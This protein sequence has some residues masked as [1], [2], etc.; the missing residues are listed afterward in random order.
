MSGTS[1]VGLDRVVLLMDFM[2][3]ST[4]SFPDRQLYIRSAQGEPQQSC[5]PQSAPT[6][7]VDL[8]LVLEDGEAGLYE[9]ELSTDIAMDSLSDRS[10]SCITL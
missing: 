3:R 4:P 5:G 10:R 6:S 9:G 8:F 1:S 7:E 2:C